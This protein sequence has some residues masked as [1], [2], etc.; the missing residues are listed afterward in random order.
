M[1]LS[2]VM[3]LSTLLSALAV[4]LLITMES[5][6]VSQSQLTIQNNLLLM[7]DQIKNVI[8]DSAAWNETVESPFNTLATACIRNFTSPTLCDHSGAP[9]LAEPD[10]SLLKPNSDFVSVDFP[11][12]RR[13]LR[14]DSTVLLSAAAGSGF[15]DQGQAC[16][17]FSMNPNTGDPDCPVSWDVRIQFLCP[18]AAATCRNPEIRFVILLY[19][20]PGPNRR[21]EQTINQNRFRMVLTRGETG[22]LKNETFE[23]SYGNASNVVGGG[24]CNPLG[25]R[26][27]PLN[28]IDDPTVPANA[29]LT[30][31]VLNLEPGTYSC[32]ASTSCWECG[33]L[34]V[35]LFDASGNRVLA[36]SPAIL[37]GPSI[38]ARAELNNTKFTINGR[39]RVRV[40]HFCQSLP[41]GG[42]DQYTM[43][44][45]VQ[46]YS[47]NKFAVV[48][49]SRLY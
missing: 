2:Q 1:I 18:L 29:T 6:A 23:A 24:V 26:N 15:N 3:F 8:L 40:Q 35:R 16:N 49:C 7:R 9:P 33:T 21:P 27:I 34:A 14:A 38:L 11:Q 5:N 41:G 12:L 28:V 4:S 39:T 32:S 47:N 20:H 43:G 25:W 48:R 19:Y 36:T 30:A 44:M 22:P 17:T 42:M 37:V 31:G 13:V 45:P 46:D 10:L